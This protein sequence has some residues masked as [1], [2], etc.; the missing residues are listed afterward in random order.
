MDILFLISLLPGMHLLCTCV[1]H[2][3]GSFTHSSS[4]SN[5]KLLRFKLLPVPS[6]VFLVLFLLHCDGVSR[7]SAWENSGEHGNSVW[8][9]EWTNDLMDGWRDE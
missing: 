3:C 4:W 1:F 7:R 6:N 9:F 2:L 8:L 5:A